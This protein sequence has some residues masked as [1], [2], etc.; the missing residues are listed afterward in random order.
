M[1]RFTELVAPNIDRNLSLE[2]AEALL[3]AM[4]PV[5]RMRAM[6]GLNEYVKETYREILGLIHPEWCDIQIRVELYRLQQREREYPL[7]GKQALQFHENVERMMAV[8][9]EVMGKDRYEKL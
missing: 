4:G 2:E 5:D 1:S 3:D 9:R 7:W 6:Y 8:S